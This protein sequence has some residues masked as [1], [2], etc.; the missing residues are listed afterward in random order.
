MREDCW[1]GVETDGF[2]IVRMVGVDESF[3]G[4]VEGDSCLL[5]GDGIVATLMGC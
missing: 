2:T 1:E 3:A 4:T 5:S